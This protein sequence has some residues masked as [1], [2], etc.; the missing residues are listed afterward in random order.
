MAGM[1]MKGNIRQR[2]LSATV[3]AGVLVALA[4]IDDR[5]RERL[6]GLTDVERSLAPWTSRVEGMIDTVA[7][8]ARNQSIDNGPVVIFGVVGAVL[9]LFMWRT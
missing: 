5:L 4:S 1:A 2:L 8:V 7:A 9:V 3:F 6:A